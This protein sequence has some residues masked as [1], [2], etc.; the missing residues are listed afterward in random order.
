MERDDSASFPS[1]T[2]APIRPP[3]RRKSFQLVSSAGRLKDWT[4]ST[5]HFAPKRSASLRAEAVR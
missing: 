3:K 2:G 4:I 1:E 5:A